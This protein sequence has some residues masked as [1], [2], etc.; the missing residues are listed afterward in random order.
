MS[1][2]LINFRGPRG[3][4]VK[5]IQ[6]YLGDNYV[7]DVT[8]AKF[9]DEFHEKFGGKRK[10]TNW[11]AAPVYKAQRLLED[12]YHAGMLDRGIVTLGA[13]WQP[14]FPK[15]AYGYTLRGGS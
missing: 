15:W 10:E 13:N 4:Q 14:G 3:E 9:H 6:E 12:M 1:N 8:D 5:F 2:W 11:G 7:T